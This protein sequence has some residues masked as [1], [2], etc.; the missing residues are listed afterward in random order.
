MYLGHGKYCGNEISENIKSCDS[1]V[2]EF[3]NSIEN[4]GQNVIR[5]FER[6]PPHHTSNLNLVNN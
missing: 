4:D 2:S 5:W 1:H 6:P 3:T